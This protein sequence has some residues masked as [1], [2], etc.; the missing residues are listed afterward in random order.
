MFEVLM[1]RSYSNGPQENQAL[2]WWSPVQATS[3]L[4]RDVRVEE[5]RRDFEPHKAI[6]PS[7]HTNLTTFFATL[8]WFSGV[9][10]NREYS[11][12][13][14]NIWRPEMQFTNFDFEKWWV[15]IAKSGNDRYVIAWR[16]LHQVLG[17]A[18]TNWSCV[19]RSCSLHSKHSSSVTCIN[20][21]G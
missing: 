13:F 16:S 12:I 6:H 3:D 8:P 11:W 4:D 15:I 5:I 21:P 7:K 18:L 17:D 10:S 1:F 19:L 9:I 2:P 20:P 14:V